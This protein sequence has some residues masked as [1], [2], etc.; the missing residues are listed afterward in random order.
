MNA[1]LL[2]SALS[3]SHYF[4][5]LSGVVVRGVGYYTK[6]PEYE[7]RDVDLSFLGPTSRCTQKLVAGRRQVHS[8]V[9]LVDLAVR[10]FPW[11]S[12]KLA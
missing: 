10:S 6:G 3:I 1:T 7:F 12:P 8:S 11:F 9:A 2:F 4:G 5:R